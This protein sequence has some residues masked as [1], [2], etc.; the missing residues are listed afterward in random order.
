M[1]YCNC[2]SV[3]DESFPALSMLMGSSSNQHRFYLEG[4]DYLLFDN[5]YQK[6]AVLIKEELGAT[7]NMWLLGDPFLRAYYSIYD[8]DQAK[9][10]MV[11]IAKTYRSSQEGD[12]SG[13]DGYVDGVID[14][15]F[16]RLGIDQDS[17][18]AVTIIGGL[19][20]AICFF[21]CCCCVQYCFIKCR[22]KSVESQREK[23]AREINELAQMQQVQQQFE[24]QAE[25]KR[26]QE[27]IQKQLSGR[28]A[29]RLGQLDRIKH[30]ANNDNPHF[31]QN[32]E[33]KK[34]EFIKS[35][36]GQSISPM[37]VKKSIE[38]GEKSEILPPNMMEEQ[39]QTYKA[40]QASLNEAVLSGQV[41]KVS[42]IN[43]EP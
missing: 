31:Q 4:K 23:S 11:G 39:I 12:S 37:D 42:P 27:E 36:R 33:F 15:F 7:S 2:E 6:C 13:A 14:S 9:I 34:R 8:M 43:Q 32:E 1:V 41:N 25:I 20:F 10:G 3:Q 24:I 19:F 22:N 5:Y 16:S 18:L 26:E 17:E 38:L 29:E 40:I 28:N 35:G 21:C 30:L